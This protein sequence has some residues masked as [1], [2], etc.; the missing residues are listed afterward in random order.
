MR[1]FFQQYILEYVTVALVAEVLFSCVGV[2]EPANNLQL[3]LTQKLLLYSSCKW[4]CYSLSSA[5]LFVTLWSVHGIL[6]EQ[7]PEWVAIPFSRGSS[8]PRDWT[9]R[10]N[11]QADSLLCKI[12]GTAYKC[13]SFIVTLWT[14]ARQAPLSMESSKKEY[15]SESSFPSPGE[16][17]RPMDRTHVSCIASRFFTV[18]DTM[19]TSVPFQCQAAFSGFY[20]MPVGRRKILYQNKCAVSF[21]PV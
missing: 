18:R 17:S 12:P 8:W 20:S 3:P 11:L 10:L 7:I 2:W 6:Q 9:S 14:V 5:W 4:K 21:E 15:W 1:I 19:H 13:T 16:S